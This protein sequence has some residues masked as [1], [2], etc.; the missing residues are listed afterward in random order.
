MVFSPGQQSYWPQTFPAV[1]LSAIGGMTF[2]NVTNVFVSSS[3]AREDQGLGQGIFNTIVQT[4]T[5]ISLAIAATVAHSGGVSVNS[6]KE[7][8]LKGYHYAFWLCIGILGLPFICVWFLKGTKAGSVPQNEENNKGAG[9]N[10][11]N[12]PE[13]NNNNTTEEEK[14]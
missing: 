14:L 11:E 13:E 7:E 2:F 8:L 5:A 10:E 3:V 9:N 6:T 12:K 4:S 1:V